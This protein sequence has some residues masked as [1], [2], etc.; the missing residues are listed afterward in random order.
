MQ[1][2]S[3]ANPYLSDSTPSGRYVRIE[4]IGPR[5]TRL[6]QHMAVDRGQYLLTTEAPLDVAPGEIQGVQG[7][8]VVSYCE[9]LTTK[10]MWDPRLS[11]R[12]KNMTN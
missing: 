3:R 11:R 1:S 4:A 12:V 10:E 9:P 2:Y 7:E 6:P 5:D 8:A